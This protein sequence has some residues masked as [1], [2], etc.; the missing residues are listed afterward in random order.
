MTHIRALNARDPYIVVDQ[1]AKKYYLYSNKPVV[2]RDN[3]PEIVV[4]ESDDLIYWSEPKLAYRCDDDFWGPLDYWAPEVHLWKGKYYL[5]CS[6]RNAG[7]YRAC[8]CHVADTPSGPFKPIVNKPVTPEGWHCLDGTLYVDRSGAPW[9]VFCHEWTQVQDGQ[10]AAIKLS[11]DL[12]EAVSEPVILFRASQAPWKGD[13]ITGEKYPSCLGYGRVTDGCFLHR[14]ENGELLMLWSSFS[15]TGYTVGYAKSEN[16]GIMGPWTQE[17]EPLFSQDGGHSMMFTSL[18]GKL[19]MTLHSP[20]ITGQEKLLMFEM[21]ENDGKLHIVN[22]LTG[23][24][25]F[26]KYFEDGSKKSD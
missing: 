23:N 15:D 20:N 16:G 9:M 5:I 14:A 3:K 6:Y 4:Y 8:Q 21:E 24:W 2:L 26:N 13:P 22:E 18:E 11:D 17:P 19:M 12:S 10:I 7:G 1:K 25:L